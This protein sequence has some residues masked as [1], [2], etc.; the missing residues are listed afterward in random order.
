METKNY[1]EKVKELKEQVIDDI[2]K[3]M[4]KM[5]FA[6]TFET[7]I[8]I[9]DHDG[10]VL[11]QGV[12]LNPIDNGIILLFEDYQEEG[13]YVIQHPVEELI[14]I[15]KSLREQYA[16]TEYSFVPGYYEYHFIN[17]K[18]DILLNLNDPS[19]HCCD[20]DGNPI[21]DFQQLKDEMLD[22]ISE[23]RDV[24]K[25]GDE[26]LN[27]NTLDMFNQLPEDEIAAEIMARALWNDYVA[28]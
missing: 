25:A 1:N 8:M 7:P 24:L 26:D 18:G 5:G 13:E 20:S 16:K 22:V 28:N 2:R 11:L 4:K 17:L 23:I 14:F 27:G 6:W 15:L 19:D 9:D 12:D 21:E 10:E 3:E